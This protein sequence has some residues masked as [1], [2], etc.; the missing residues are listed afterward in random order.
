MLDG[1]SLV[2][3]DADG[4]ILAELRLSSPAFSVSGGVARAYRLNGPARS[5]GVPVAFQVRRA[6]GS[7]V[8]EGEVGT[9]L[10]IDHPYIEAG[11]NIQVPSFTYAETLESA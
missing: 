2:L 3:T 5:S 7:V 10:L 6:D 8:V 4:A 1:G 9:D 11:A